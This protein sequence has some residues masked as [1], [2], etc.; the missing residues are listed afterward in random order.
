MHDSNQSVRKLVRHKNLRSL[1][2]VYPSPVNG[3]LHVHISLWFWAL[4]DAPEAQ[5]LL[6][7]SLWHSLVPE[8]DWPRPHFSLEEQSESVR[9]PTSMQKFSG[10]PCRPLG[11][12]QKARWDSTLHSA[13]LPQILFKQGSMHSW[14]TH[15]LENGQSRSTWH[16]SETKNREFYFIVQHECVT[17]YIWAQ[18]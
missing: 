18:L 2:S 10:F 12:K 7:Q 4:Q 17:L 8:K 9:Q 15:A 5:G 16:S 1:H 11:Q 3:G 14:F 13:F 6:R